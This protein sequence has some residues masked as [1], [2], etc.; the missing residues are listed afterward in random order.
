[1]IDLQTEFIKSESAGLLEKNIKFMYENLK[2]LNI[3]NLMNL[4]LEEII[5]K[6]EHSNL[7]VIEKNF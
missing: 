5:N 7:K 6:I 2:K 4:D 3:I 1:M